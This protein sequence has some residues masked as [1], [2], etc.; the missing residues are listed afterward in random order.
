M[1]EQYGPIYSI[2]FITEDSE[3]KNQAFVQFEESSGAQNAKHM[4]ETQQIDGT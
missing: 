4:L 2:K 1:C 3:L